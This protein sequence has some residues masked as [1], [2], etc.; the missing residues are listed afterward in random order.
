MT[1]IACMVAALLVAPLVRRNIAEGDGASCAN[2]R[3]AFPD[4]DDRILAGTADL[5]GFG[6]GR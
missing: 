6:R 3:E 4:P 2:Y 5:Q 1:P